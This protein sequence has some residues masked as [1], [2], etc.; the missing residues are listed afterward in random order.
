MCGIIGALAP[1]GVREVLVEGL[2]RMEYR[3]YDS[4]GICVWD[5]NTLACV[6]AAG[7][8]ENLCRR[9]ADHPVDGPVGIGHTRWATHGK[10]SEANA[11]PHLAEGVAV[12]HNGIIENHAAL[13]RRLEAEGVCFASETDTEVIAHGVAARLRRNE[14]PESAWR[15]SLLELE[16]AYAL[17]GLIAGDARRLWFARRG[18]PLL[19]G[20]S[21][22]G[23]RLF[24]ASDALA[25]AGLADEICYLAEGDW[26]WLS[27]DGCALFNLDGRPSRLRWEP[28]PVALTDTGKAGFS[29]YMEKEIHEQPA[30]LERIMNAYAADGGIVFPR[31]DGLMNGLPK[32]IVMVACGT[33][34]HAAL[35]A[36]Y[37]LEGHLRVPVEVDVASEYRYRDPVIGPDTLLIALSQSGETADTL[38]AL[39]LFKRRTPD[40]PALA[41]CNVPASTMAREAD[42]LIELHAGPEIGVASTK[43][44]MAQLAVLA[45]ISLQLASRFGDLD[46]GKLRRHLAALRAA[47]GDVAG[48]LAHAGDVR[49]AL[50][51]FAD[52]VGA[53]YLGRGP[54]YPVALEGALKLK[55]IS[56]LHAEGYAAGEMKHGPIALVDT[57]LPVVVIAPHQY[58]LEKVLS[59]LHEVRARGARV[60][61]LTDLAEPHR[62][63]EVALRLT[64][65]AGDEFT[66]PILAAV[67]LQLLAYE[68]ARAR[69]ADVD[70]PRNL[71]KSVTV[72]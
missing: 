17:A 27:H 22:K 40:N 12:V 29:H 30:V 11:H 15:E 42:G 50:P 64:I 33:S 6:K 38:E 51:L 32:R 69:G 52:A 72:E 36:R 31:A 41:I 47:S 3:G 10:P 67:P 45:L 39:R 16:G 13:R 14:A 28:M 24:V 43:A 68:V 18:S 5:R 58:H 54:C 44:Y 65:P 66:T 26:G 49:A 59:N 53:L 21:G 62:P 71:A 34:Y 1:G 7:K 63:E 48:M 23:E 57:R 55:E 35:T 25:L 70:Q 20:R 60:I 56:Y 4:A 2:A 37:W 9:L 19:L 61:L 8:L 46:D